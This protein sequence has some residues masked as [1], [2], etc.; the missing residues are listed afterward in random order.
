MS[1]T[2]RNRQVN[3]TQDWGSCMIFIVS[4]VCV[5]EGAGNGGKEQLRERKL[6][7]AK[8]LIHSCISCF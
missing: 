5:R 2:G 8:G 3:R 1:A 6:S 4:G 7:G